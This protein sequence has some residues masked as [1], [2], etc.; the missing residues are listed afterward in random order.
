MFRKG[1]KIA[2]MMIM[3]LPEVCMEYHQHGNAYSHDYILHM[4]D[5]RLP[6]HCCNPIHVH[7]ASQRQRDSARYGSTGDMATPLAMGQENSPESQTLIDTYRQHLNDLLEYAEATKD[8]DPNDQ[9]NDNFYYTWMLM[10]KD[11]EAVRKHQLVMGKV[12]QLIQPAQTRRNKKKSMSQTDKTASTS[13]ISP[14]ETITE[15][16]KQR[17]RP[18]KGKNPKKRPSPRYSDSSE[19]SNSPHKKQTSPL[20][21]IGGETTATPDKINEPAEKEQS[22]TRDNDSDMSISCQAESE[23]EHL[24]TEQSFRNTEEEPTNTAQDDP[25]Y[26]IRE[27]IEDMV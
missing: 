27:L 25:E 2:Q 11:K 8:F 13:K 5:D 9:I 6:R 10:N 14:N 26:L 23:Q 15:P 16:R 7:S 3:R 17:N 24:A 22:P 21:P 18:E 20:K 12:S 19:T 1:F 4:I